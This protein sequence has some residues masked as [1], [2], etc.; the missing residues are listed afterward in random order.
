MAEIMDALA[1]QLEDNLTPPTGVE[2][3]IE[4]RAFSIAEQPSIDMLIPSATGL[5]EGLAGFGSDTRYGAFPL[6]IRAKVSTADVYAGEDMLLDMIDDDG[7]MS[8][9]AALDADRTLGGV[10]DSLTWGHGFP[11][12]GYTD[13]PTPDGNGIL[14]GST[15]SLVIVKT[16]S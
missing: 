7:P 3:H 15:M 9:V 8:I 10:C 11:W 1:E 12:S 2:L 13:F 4:P 5:E 14:L 6:V 16:Q